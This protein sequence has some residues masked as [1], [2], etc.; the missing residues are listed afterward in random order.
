M[1]CGL[2]KCVCILVVMFWVI[3]WVKNGVGV[4]VICW[5]ISLSNSGGIVEFLV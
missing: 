5:N 2:I 3:G 4:W 1:I